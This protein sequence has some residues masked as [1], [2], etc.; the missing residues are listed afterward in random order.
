MPSK[1]SPQVVTRFDAVTR[2]GLRAYA[3]ADSITLSELIRRII[4]GW[5]TDESYPKQGAGVSHPAGGV[6]PTLH[7][8]DNLVKELE[9]QIYG[10]RI[11]ASVDVQA[12]REGLYRTALGILKDAVKLS[13][14]EALAKKAEARMVAMQVATQASLSAGCFLRDYERGD[15]TA[16]VDQLVKTNELLKTKLREFEEGTGKATQGS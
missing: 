7:H 12:E 16:L 14:N 15:I 9:L 4:K 8:M 3:V 13:E 6:Y 11:A 5:V 2:Q 10:I 1:G